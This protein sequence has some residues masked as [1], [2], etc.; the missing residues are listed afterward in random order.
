M[1][2]HDW[3]NYLA[4]AE[5]LGI[6]VEQAMALALLAFLRPLK[7]AMLEVQGMVAEFHRVQFPERW[8]SHPPEPPVL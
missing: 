1:A 5:E 4:V 2:R 3:P 6:T 8:Q 7:D